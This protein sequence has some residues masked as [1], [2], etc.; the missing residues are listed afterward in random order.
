[1]GIV[2]N[3]GITRDKLLANMDAGRWDSLIAVNL[4]A[5]LR[6]NDQLLKARGQGVLADNFRITSLSS[7]SGIAGNRGQTNYGAAKDGIIGMTQAPAPGL[8]EEGGTPQDEATIY[9]E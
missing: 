1:D 2:H 5:P 6:I 4:S 3:A 9:I 8:D 7:T